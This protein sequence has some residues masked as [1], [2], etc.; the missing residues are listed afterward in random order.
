VLDDLSGEAKEVCAFSP[1]LTYA[2]PLH[3]L[4]EW[5]CMNKL[6]DL[7]DEKRLSASEMKVQS[8]RLKTKSGLDPI[9]RGR[10][11][12]SGHAPGSLPCH[13]IVY[14]LVV[15]EL[16]GLLLGEDDLPHPQIDFPSFEK[17]LTSA[18]ERTALVYNPIHKRREQ[19]VNIRKLRS[20]YG[21]AGSYCCTIS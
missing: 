4:R 2:M 19:W 20:S 3:R 5:G 6:M 13:S 12:H 7:L 9:M 15:Q 18:L 14:V 1:W 11:R 8:P 17:A 21:G 10:L 16:V